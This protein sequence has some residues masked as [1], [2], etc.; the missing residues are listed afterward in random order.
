MTVVRGCERCVRTFGAGTVVVEDSFVGDVVGVGVAV[1]LVLVLV[2]EDSAVDWGSA[3][4]GAGT[5]VVVVSAADA[6][7]SGVGAVV[8]SANATS[9]GASTASGSRSAVSDERIVMFSCRVG[10]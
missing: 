7:P 5:F 4:G 8:L 1:V 10:S 9:P 2:G 6:E 3:V